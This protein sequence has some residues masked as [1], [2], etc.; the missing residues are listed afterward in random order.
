MH[1][2]KLTKDK[3]YEYDVQPFTGL[4]VNVDET[5]TG[6]LYDVEMIGEFCRKNYLF[7]VCDCVSSFLADPFDMTSCGADVMLT[8]SQKVLVK[9]TGSPVAPVRTLESMI[10]DNW[11]AL[12]RS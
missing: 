6:V 2:Q 12:F 10:P 4:L 11:E 7:Y 5:S 1:G 9:I 3:P 8:G